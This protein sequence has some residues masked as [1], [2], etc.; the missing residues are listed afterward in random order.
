[1]VIVTDDPVP[2]A[3]SA[4]MA[5][6]ARRMQ[7]EHSSVEMTLQSITTAALE[8][9]PGVEQA[10]I[11][12]VTGQYTI[13]SRAATSEVPRILDEIQQ[14]LREGPCVQ[15]AW[16]HETVYAEDL[17]ETTR[18]PEFA[19]AAVKLGVRSM[20]SFQLFTYGENLG[21]LNLYS[22]SPQAFGADSYDAGLALATHAAIVLVAAQ[23]E[24]QWVSAL[25]SRDIIGQAKGMLMERFA[26][27]AAQA[28][29]LIRQLSQESNTK[30]VDV[31]RAIVDDRPSR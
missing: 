20:L 7:Q 15:S 10:G 27:D 3:F 23:R 16:E 13:E 4:K 1:M 5:D 28:F 29:T 18:W 22:R 2:G 30:L 9:V 24:S 12:L 26:I 6:A 21:A 11:T 31:A 25:A 19:K 14:E 17:A 8:N